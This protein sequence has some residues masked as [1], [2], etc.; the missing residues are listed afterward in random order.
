ML[1]AL[2]AVC[3]STAAATCRWLTRSVR[4]IGPSASSSPA[5]DGSSSSACAARFAAAANFAS[6][7]FT[8]NFRPCCLM[9]RAVLPLPRWYRWSR[10]FSADDILAPCS[11]ASVGSGLEWELEVPASRLDIAAGTSTRRST[12]T[13]TAGDLQ[14]ARRIVTILPE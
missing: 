6:P 9:P 13:T 12:S 8:D 2:R 10:C 7:R 11:T 1:Y 14:F 3:S 4:S 5:S